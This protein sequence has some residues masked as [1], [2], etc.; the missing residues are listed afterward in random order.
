MNIQITKNAWKK[1]TEIIHTSKNQY[2]MIFSASSGGCNGFNFQLDLL[3][4]G[5]HQKINQNKFL[6]ILKNNESKVYIDPL[7]EMYLL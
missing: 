6:T 1:I 3:T 2:G 7:S 5:I 4:N